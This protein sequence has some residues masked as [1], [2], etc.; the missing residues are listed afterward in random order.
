[1]VDG[2]RPV[3]RWWWRATAWTHE[4]GSVGTS[5]GCITRRRRPLKNAGG[6][7]SIS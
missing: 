6:G 1:M 7:I 3:T 4:L 5:T 2:G